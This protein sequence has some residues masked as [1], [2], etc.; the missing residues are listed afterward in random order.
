ML[1]KPMRN[2]LLTLFIL[3]V[4]C[5][6]RVTTAEPSD[7]EARQAAYRE[8]YAAVQA[9][10]WDEAYAIFHRLWIEAPSY[11][12]ALHLGHAE[13]NLGKARDAAEH[14]AFG[15]AHLPPGEAKELGENSRRALDRVKEDVGTLT[16]LVDRSGA[17]VRVD[18]ESRGT[19]PID[20][21]IFVDPGAHVIE[22][23][24]AGYQTATQNFQVTHGEHRNIVLQLD[25]VVLM[26][27]GSASVPAAAPAASVAP[28]PHGDYHGGSSARTVALLSGAGVTVAA[29]ITTLV[30]ALNGSAAANRADDARAEANRYGPNACATPMA[31]PA[32]VCASIKNADDDRVTANRNANISLAV[33]GV[34]LLATATMFIVWPRRATGKSATLTVAPSASRNSGALVLSGTF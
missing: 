19:T 28:P 22:A 29:G 18:G 9:K 16:V 20:F 12:V 32:S 14:L 15:I 34:A 5:V 33:T 24:L 10:K 26:P 2:V 6:S 27:A 7:S 8:G 21:E 4:L 11:D 17:T 30:F 31:A 25:P 3:A 23:T 1:Q 13:F